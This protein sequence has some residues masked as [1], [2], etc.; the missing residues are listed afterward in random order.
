MADITS[1]QAALIAANTKLTGASSGQICVNVCTSPDTVTWA[2]NDR[3]ISPTPIPIGSRILASTYVVHS[4]MGTSVTADLGLFDVNG[5]AIDVDGIADGIN[6]ASAGRTLAS[7]G[8]MVAGGVE[9]VTTQVSYPGLTLLD[10]TPTAN[11]QIRFEV[12]YLA[13]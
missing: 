9:Y 1:K 13:P 12:H 8:V 2:Q 10:A 3:L 7:S 6:V 4:A 5:T 11:A